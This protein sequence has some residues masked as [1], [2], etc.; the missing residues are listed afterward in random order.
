MAK[1]VNVYPD[2]TD[3]KELLIIIDE[4]KRKDMKVPLDPPLKNRGLKKARTL[5][6]PHRW[7]HL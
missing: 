3:K 5:E 6:L 4:Y 1:E 2:Y 7:N